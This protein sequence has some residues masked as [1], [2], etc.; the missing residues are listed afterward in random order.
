MAVLLAGCQALRHPLP[1]VDALSLPKKIHVTSKAFV[2]GGKIPLANSN[3]GAG[4]SPDLS[5]TGVPAAAQSLVLLVQDPDTAQGLYTHW[6]LYNISPKTQTLPAGLP[7]RRGTLK[8]GLQGENDSGLLG[9]FG[10]MPPDDKPH[11][12]HFQ[13][14]ALNSRMRPRPGYDTSTI[15]AS[16]HDHAIAGGDLVGLFKKP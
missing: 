11:H 15:L 5:W 8:E 1:V 12:Y 4:I 10:P 7:P 6:I 3:Y 14:I 2:Q 9:Y 13:I 16:I